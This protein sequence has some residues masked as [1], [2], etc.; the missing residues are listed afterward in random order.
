MKFWGLRGPSSFVDQI[1]HAVRDG[2]NVIAR[3]P[4]R[5]PPELEREIRERLHSLFEWTTIDASSG[6]SEPVDLLRRQVCP[7]VSAL[8]AASMSELADTAAFQG[9]LIWLDKIARRDWSRWSGALLAYAEA[10]RNVDLLSRTIFVVMLTGEAV[11]DESPEEAALVRR[12]FRGVVDSLDLFVFALWNAPAS[13]HDREHRAMFAQTVAQLAQ[14]D[15]FLADLLLS[16][17][18]EEALYPTNTLREYARNQGWTA[19]TPWRWELGTVDGQDEQ[20]V[21][22]SA[23]LA[24]SGD[25]RQVRQRVWAAQAGVLLPLIE[26][27]RVQ[28]IP[29]CRRYLKLPVEIE[30]QWVNDPLDIEVGQLARHLER[31]ET[32][33]MVRKQVRR[34]RDARNMLAH[35]EPLDPARA[36]YLANFA[37][38]RVR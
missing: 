13:I 21:V 17:S 27:R 4:C 19:D 30:G 25:S 14:W 33:P 34:L 38:A 5:T 9:R 18:L 37:K 32:P 10:C 1:E 8:R 28:L 15:Y 7:E 6:E 3:F 35:M 16:L 24:V 36:L 2:Y 23:L 22:H 31:T 29:Y 11:T 20:P 26:E 12:D